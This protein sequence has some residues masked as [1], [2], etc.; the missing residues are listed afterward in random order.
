MAAMPS[1]AGAASL[2]ETSL[3]QEANS[4]HS[5]Q[6]SQWLASASVDDQGQHWLVVMNKLN[7]HKLVYPLPARAHQVLKHPGKPWL[8]VA[9]RRPGQYVIVVDMQ[10]GQLLKNIVPAPD[11]HFC[12]HMLFSQDGRYLYTTENIST[13]SDGQVVVR[14]VED[15]FKILKQWPSGGLGPHQM[16]FL[17]DD[18]TLVIANGGIHTRGR[19]K[20]N[21]DSMESNLSYLNMDSGELIKQVKLT[22][23]LSKLSIR[24]IDINQH[25][26]VLIAMQHQGDKTDLVPLVAVHNMASGLRYLE[27]ADNDYFL[28]QHYCGSACFDLSGACMAIS[29]PRGDSVLFW[30]TRTAKFL[31]KYKVR[32]G[33]GLAA[34]SVADEFVVS[35]G[36]GR[37]YQLNPRTGSKKLLSKS[38]NMHFDNHL[39]SV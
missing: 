14:D 21:L 27:I 16:K 19:D 5:E 10:T 33:C 6:H 9:A 2:L 13:T 31:G 32:D 22:A 35:S 29:A 26:D 8:F 20:L 7:E 34:S 4:L 3:A 18:K 11:Q 23:D 38:A 12:G 39:A 1:L 36:K 37:L 17:T 28:L 15:D 24:H 30:D 25:N